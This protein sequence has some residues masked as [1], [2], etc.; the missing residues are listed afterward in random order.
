MCHVWF[1]AIVG[2]Q[3]HHV[4]LVGHPMN[5]TLPCSLI[6]HV[7]VLNNRLNDIGSDILSRS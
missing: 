3:R 4:L 5:Q 1:G 2:V 6:P 7:E